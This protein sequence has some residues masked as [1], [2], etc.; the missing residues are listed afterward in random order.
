M[1]KDEFEPKTFK[2]RYIL[3]TT[4]LHFHLWFFLVF[5]IVILII[6]YYNV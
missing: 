2:V 5:I 4:K 3:L 1:Q 6:Y